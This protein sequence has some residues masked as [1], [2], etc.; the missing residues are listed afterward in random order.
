MTPCAGGRRTSFILR[1]DDGTR[2]PTG[3]QWTT[4]AH[5]L[6]IGLLLETTQGHAAPKFTGELVGTSAGTLSQGAELDATRALRAELALRTSWSAQ[7]PRA[8]WSLQLAGKT[9]FEPVSSAGA[10]QASAPTF[11]PV[12]GAGA[13]WAASERLTWS[14]AGRAQAS[15]GGVR[16]SELGTDSQA[17][18]VLEVNGD[19]G[20][21]PAASGGLFGGQTGVQTGA[22]SGVQTGALPLGLAHA[23]A[24]VAV[25]YAWSQAALAAGVHADRSIPLACSD[26]DPALEA[27]GLS[28][29]ALGSRQLGLRGQ[30]E[31][32][33]APTLSARATASIREDLSLR[34][35][36]GL[37]GLP[38]ARPES[39][40]RLV[41]LETGLSRR[42]ESG[43][44]SIQ[45]GM[46]AATTQMLASS[47]DSGADSAAD[48][49]AD[50]A[51]DSGT[52]DAPAEDDAALAWA[53][54]MEGASAWTL[55]PTLDAQLES[56]G[57]LGSWKLKARADVSRL[58]GRALPTWNVG[59]DVQGI[60][61][62]GATAALAGTLSLQ[63]SLTLGD[64]GLGDEGLDTGTPPLE[65]SPPLQVR[66]AQVGLSWSPR[67]W[68]RG[69]VGW[70]LIARETF[71]AELEQRLF[72]V[73]QAL[74]LSC[75]LALDPGQRRW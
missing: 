31:R 38:E 26:S 67:W 1:R 30:L 23:G 6:A 51:V 34:G 42:L 41:S 71:P 45:V 50:S 66:T 56:R 70:S 73:G 40:S 15:L 63:Q 39:S 54:W 52:L 53:S 37:T 2:I 33:L 46:T 16:T 74:A 27:L 12:L 61:P 10:T 55:K 21:L 4:R 11:Q 8:S 65:T 59:G 58:P 25:K 32:G 60:L 29:G 36:C 48:S 22:L 69:A 24:D 62:L 5:L 17:M 47:T 28:S 64:E 72:L 19:E 35:G 43:S 14:V 3:F 44:M 68:I 9:D 13:S 75:S 18:P 57:I 49:G 20:T 7:R